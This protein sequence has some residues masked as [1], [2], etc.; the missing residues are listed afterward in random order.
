MN[1]PTL[2]AWR[3][4]GSLALLIFGSSGLLCLISLQLDLVS[5]RLLTKWVPAVVLA[6]WVWQSTQGKP[7]LF[8]TAGLLL[9]A[10]GDVSLEGNYVAAESGIPWFAVGL[11]FFLLAHLCYVPLFLSLAHHLRWQRMLPVAAYIGGFMLLLCD[12]LGVLRV[13]VIVYMTVISFMVWT[14]LC[15]RPASGHAGL[16][17]WCA[18]WGAVCFA[19]SD[20]MIAINKFLTPFDGARELILLSY[21]L[22]QFG[23]AS[24]AVNFP[25]RSPPHSTASQ[26]Y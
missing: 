9:S 3:Y 25:R 17:R 21:W 22:A 12:T 18:A 7:R 4:P 2:T 11:G 26:A 23:I 13:P 15:V 1:Q 10:L 14:A 6:V 16:W 19:A 5:L 24:A 8:A 20:S